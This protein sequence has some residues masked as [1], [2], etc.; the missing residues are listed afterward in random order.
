MLLSQ[1]DALL[2]DALQEKA[3][4][5]QKDIEELNSVAS[6]DIEDMLDGGSKQEDGQKE[7]ASQK[8]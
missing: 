3:A 7:P 2:Q 5:E 8:I 6:C 1:K 4:A